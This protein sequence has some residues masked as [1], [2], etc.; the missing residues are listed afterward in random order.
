MRLARSRVAEYPRWSYVAEHNVQLPDE[1]D[2]IHNDLE[3]FWGVEPADLR[4]TQEELEKK[5]D[6]YTLGKNEEGKVDVLA[7]AFEEGR[8]DHYI[9]ASVQVIGLLREIQDYLPSFR[10]TFSP[11]DGPNRL[12]DHGILTAVLDAAFSQTGM[13]HP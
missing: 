10:A 9:R 2:Q 4:K 7:W 3:P 12:S 1:Y 5:K 13:S 6:S 8:Y 11:H